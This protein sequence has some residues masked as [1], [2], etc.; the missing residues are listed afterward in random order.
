MS[1]QFV[2]RAFCPRDID[3]F[4]PDLIHIHIARDFNGNNQDVSVMWSIMKGIELAY[5][6]PIKDLHNAPFVFTVVVDGDRE[7]E[8]DAIVTVTAATSVV[9]IGACR[10]YVFSITQSAD[11]ISMLD[12]EGAQEVVE[13]YVNTIFSLTNKI[14]SLLPEHSV[15]STL[16]H[17]KTLDTAKKLLTPCLNAGMIIEESK[18]LNIGNGSY[19]WYHISCCNKND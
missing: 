1:S 2:Y 11:I 8:V 15:L 13:N 10:N 3:G 19:V 16:L 6:N 18:P 12:E 14:F 7:V 9:P 5:S 17:T 4:N